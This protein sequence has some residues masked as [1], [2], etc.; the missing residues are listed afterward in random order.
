MEPRTYSA[1]E[2]LLGFYMLP[3]ND[4]W[5]WFFYLLKFIIGKVIVIDFRSLHLTFVVDFFVT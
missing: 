2:I 4:S 1:S 5:T 3:D